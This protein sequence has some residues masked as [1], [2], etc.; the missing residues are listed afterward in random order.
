MAPDLDLFFRP[1]SIAVVGA[2]DAAGR[3]NSVMTAH[4]REFALR[5]GARFHAVTPVY[6]SVLG[7]TTVPAIADV[8]DEIDL[9]VLLTGVERVVDHFAEAC[10]VGAR[11]AVIFAS[12]FS[13]IGQAGIAAEARLRALVDSGPTRLLGPNTNLN[14]FS[15][16]RS[17]LGG[18]A[19][20]L[21]TQSG[22]QGRPVFQGQELGVRLSHWAP[23]GNEVD[24]EFAHFCEYFADHDDV[25]AIAAYIE[26]FKRG[27]TLTRALDRAVLRRTPIVMVKV[28]R[29]A[30]GASMAMSHTGHLTGSDAVIDAVFRQYGVT[31]VDGLDELLEICAMFCRTRAGEPRRSSERPRGG[32]PAEQRARPGICV[33]SISG[34]TGAHMADLASAA[35]LHLPQLSAATQSALHDGLIPSFLRVSNPVDCGGPPVMDERGRKILDVLLGAPEIDA[36]IVP[37][38]GAVD[39]M[40][41]P[42]TRDLVAAAATSPK[43][44]FVV[45]GSPVGDERAYRET[46]LGSQIPVFRT[47]QNCVRAVRAWQDWSGFADEYESPFDRSV[48][49]NPQAAR[50]REVLADAPAGTTL[51]EHASKELLR[52]FEIRTTQDRLCSS[53]SESARAAGELGL[54]VVMKVSSPDLAHKSDGGLVIV[55]VNSLAQVRRVHSELLERAARVDPDA[56]IDGVLVCES[57]TDG[58]EMLV[59]VSRDDLFGPV[60]SVGLGG[61]FVEVLGDVAVA[62]PPFTERAARRMIDSL[63]GRALLHGVRGRDA[64]D[65]NALVDV[66]MKVQRLAIDLADDVTEVDIN[67]LVVRRRGAVALDAL[68]VR[69]S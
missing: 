66:I 57:V 24:L 20:A 49:S 6:E 17:D 5:H 54:P 32:Y 56:R 61:V 33:Y 10:A 44:V 41:D 68:V 64:V 55:G 43:P 11:F 28:G 60:V 48:V 65:E 22:H 8:D 50:A 36:L 38:T 25:G 15:A 52:A 4:L 7:V 47:F 35:G 53:P 51:S 63:R 37:I 58:V 31:R 46:L 18:A 69:R 26:G 34:G 14:A 59:G 62:V 3:P 27:A 9:A 39:S 1:R 16:F 29:T 12:G 19:I 42:M 23:T 2:S 21:I 67:P 30:T 13:E 40:S 45:W